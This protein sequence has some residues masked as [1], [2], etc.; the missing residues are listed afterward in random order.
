MLAATA[1]RT[2]RRPRAQ[3]SAGALG[4]DG[5]GA[6][7]PMI[8][9]VTLLAVADI[10]RSALGDAS[11]TG[12]TRPSADALLL[13][14]LSFHFDDFLA[15]GCPDEVGAGE[16][17]WSFGNGGTGGIGLESIERGTAYIATGSNG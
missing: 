1:G 10:G 15:M 13:P 9:L 8:R 2:P 17:A 4:A 3:S 16:G 11:S 7:R 12:D 14:K 6:F 5:G